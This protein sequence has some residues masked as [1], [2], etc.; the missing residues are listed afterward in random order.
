MNTL[1]TIRKPFGIILPL[2]EVKRRAI[3]DALDR[4]D[5]NYPLAASVLGLGRTTVYRMAKMYK[6]QLPKVQAEG[7]MSV[8]QHLLFQHRIPTVSA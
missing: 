3:C 6:Y 2:D 7:L 5:G 8:P 4:C 1:R